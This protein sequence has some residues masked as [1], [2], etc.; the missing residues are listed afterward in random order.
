MRPYRYELTNKYAIWID[1]DHI[2]AITEPHSQRLGMYYGFDITL[3][4]NNE[5]LFIRHSLQ[6]I[7]DKSK[8]FTHERQVNPENHPEK[9]V[10]QTSPLKAKWQDLF[11]AWTGATP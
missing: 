5:S 7:F 6:L 9:Y 8:T 3:A 10:D 4:F 1:L 11:D 2:L